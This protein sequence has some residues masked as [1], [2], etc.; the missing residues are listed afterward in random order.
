MKGCL[1][2]LT[3]QISRRYLYYNMNVARSYTMDLFAKLTI[4]S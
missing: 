1:Q 3:K 2:Y 4:K